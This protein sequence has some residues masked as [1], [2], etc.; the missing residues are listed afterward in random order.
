[1]CIDGALRGKVYDAANKLVGCAYLPFP[2]YGID[3]MG[4]GLL[5]YVMVDK[6]NPPY[7]AKIVPINLW[8]HYTPQTMHLAIKGRK[9]THP[10]R[11]EIVQKL[12]DQWESEWASAQQT[13]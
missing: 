12:K 2:K 7:T 13:N 5:G 9:G 4:T 10:N 3:S 11:N 8:R 6:L 1:M